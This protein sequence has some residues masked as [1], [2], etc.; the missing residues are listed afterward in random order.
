MGICKLCMEQKELIRKSHI[1]PAFMYNGMFDENNKLSFQPIR[2]GAIEK[3]EIK[4]PSDGEY[5]GG[6]LCNECDNT[7]LGHYFEDYASKAMYGGRLVASECPLFQSC[8]S[9]HNIEFIKCTRINYTKYK[10][11]LLSVLWRAS[12]SNRSFFSE[13]SLG[14]KHEEEIRRMIFNK[15]AGEVDKFP[16]FISSYLNHKDLPREIIIQ[17][18]KI[19]D[20][21]LKVFVFLI[22][23]YLYTFY[24]NEENASLPAYVTAETIKPNNELNIILYSRDNAINMLKA[25][26]GLN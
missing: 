16:I 5:E 19:Q 23:G 3:H 4:R 10:L 26:A 18:R 12:I 25:Y 21:Q 8:I 22:N 15:D 13:I 20:D 11:F 1:I 9:Q 17:P 2:E 7:L 14:Q 24:V 6:L